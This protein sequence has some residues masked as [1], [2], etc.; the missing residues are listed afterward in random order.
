MANLYSAFASVPLELVD[1]PEDNV[2]QTSGLSEDSLEEFAQR[3]SSEGQIH[4]VALRPADANGRHRLVCG[5]RRYRA[6]KLLGW[7][8]IWAGILRPEIS[9]RQAEMLHHLE[10]IDRVNLNSYEQAMGARR[11][12]EGRENAITL[13]EYCQRTGSNHATLKQLMQYTRGLPKEVL[14]DW[15]NGHPLLTPKNLARLYSLPGAAAIESWAKWKAWRDGG[16][17]DSERPDS[18][19]K[20]PYKRPTPKKLC[21]AH[22]KISGMGLPTHVERFA[23]GL[24]EFAQGVRKEIPSFV[25]DS[26]A[27]KSRKKKPAKKGTT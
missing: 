3:I 1:V 17:P 20:N 5:T 15:R 25:I 7:T 21:D 23:L 19:P 4:P 27:P 6:I 2:R 24:I 8:D 12:V 11:F 10:N 22:E 14:D 18:M 26:A 13:E 16:A 9:D